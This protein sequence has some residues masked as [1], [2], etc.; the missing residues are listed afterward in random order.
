MERERLS[1]S[2]VSA[3]ELVDR[4]KR[5]LAQHEAQLA[6]A[7]EAVIRSQHEVERLRAFLNTAASYLNDVRV[8]AGPIS[9]K[10]LT[11]TE[12]LIQATIDEITRAGRHLTIQELFT[13]MLQRELRI[14]GQNP[15]QNYAGILSREGKERVKYEKDKGWTLV[16]KENGSDAEASNP[17]FSD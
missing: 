8:S 7:E 2:P 11:Q 13:R 3:Q 1:A 15:K 6:Q 5:D 16:T 14:G 10:P 9:T 4:A 17:L 12:A